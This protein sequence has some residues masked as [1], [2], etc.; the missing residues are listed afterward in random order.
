MVGGKMWDIAKTGTVL[1]WLG[2]VA[3]IV[4]AVVNHVPFCFMNVVAFLVISFC[5]TIGGSMIGGAPE[6]MGKK[7]AR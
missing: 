2:V 5:F 7:K 4:H 1:I 3:Y 6:E